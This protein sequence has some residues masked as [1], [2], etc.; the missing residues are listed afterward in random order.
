M[1]KILIAVAC[2]IFVSTG[3]FAKPVSHVPG[4]HNNHVIEHH[5]P[6]PVHVVKHAHKPAT[7][8]VHHYHYNRTDFGDVLIALAILATA[9]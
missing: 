2:A 8:V 1:K 7:H 4:H 5:A 6:K 9:M 3:A